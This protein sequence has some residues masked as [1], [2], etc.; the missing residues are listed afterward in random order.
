MNA[1]GHALV[2]VSPRETGQFTEQDNHEEVE[3]NIH[4]QP[5]IDEIERYMSAD[6][7]VPSYHNAIT[8]SGIEV[9]WLFRSVAGRTLMSLGRAVEVEAHDGEPDPSGPHGI[10]LLHSVRSPRPRSSLSDS[11]ALRSDGNYPA[12]RIAAF[13][14]L[15]LFNP[16]HEVLPIIQYFFAVMTNDSSRL[17]RRRLAESF[18]L[19]LP[20]L[21]AVHDL[22]APEMVFE[23]E[24]PT[25]KETDPLVLVIKALR[26]KTRSKAL[27]E[28]LVN[29]LT[30]V[31]VL[32][33]P[34]FSAI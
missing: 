6:R 17:I 27:R 8:V 7:L 2:A 21:V 31:L 16:L 26:K 3:G 13:D 23:E 10:L 9:R 25:K 24:E 20:V 33:S 15:L 28:A 14:A 4:L 5:A 29:T 30:C 22:A 32:R 12:V 34:S 18:L 11:N 1:L 19:S